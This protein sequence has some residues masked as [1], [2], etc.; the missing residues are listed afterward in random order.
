VKFDIAIIKSVLIAAA[1]LCGCSG[2]SNGNTGPTPTAPPG[3]ATA[4]AQNGAVVV[5][6]GS[7]TGGA[8][9]YYTVDGSAPTTSSQIY[10]ARQSDRRSWYR[11]LECDHNAGFRAQHTFRHARLVR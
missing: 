5:T 10:H 3:I 9:V 2:S 8:T 11:C 1:L 6:L 7:K 4:T